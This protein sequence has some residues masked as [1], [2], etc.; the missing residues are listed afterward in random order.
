MN[1]LLS[2]K[3]ADAVFEA[4][5]ANAIALGHNLMES[6]SLAFGAWCGVYLIAHAPAPEVELCRFRPIRSL[7]SAAHHPGE[8]K[9]IK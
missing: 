5:K 6:V 2:K 4:E 8:L 7:V 3:I 9:W 1:T